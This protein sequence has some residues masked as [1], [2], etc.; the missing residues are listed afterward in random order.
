M[1]ALADT[2]AK[3]D[4]TG[5]P[6]SD[7][8]LYHSLAGAL[9]Y[10]TFARPGITYVVQQVCLLMHDPWEPHFSALKLILRYVRGTRDHD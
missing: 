4:G 8:T 5:P 10:L 2:F 6:V 3:F 7:P 1:L 9:L